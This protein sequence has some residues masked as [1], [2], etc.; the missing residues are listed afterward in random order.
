[1]YKKLIL[2]TMGC[3]IFAVHQASAVEFVKLRNNEEVPKIL[4]EEYW[5]YLQQIKGTMFG[6]QLNLL[7]LHN[8]INQEAIEEFH[9]GGLVDEKGQV[10]PYVR[11]ILDAGTTG[12]ALATI[13]WQDP[14]APSSNK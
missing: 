1:M 11:A 2:I 3:A 4:L 12:D 10:R 13:R 7:I 6:I 8:P 9:K 5:K 14:V